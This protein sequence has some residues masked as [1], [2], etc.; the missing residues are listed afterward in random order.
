MGLTYHYKFKAPASATAA[1]LEA[2][3]NGVEEEAQRLGFEPT[4]VLNVVFVTTERKQFA[5]RLTPG[6]PVEDV[7]LKGADL[8]D[9]SRVWHHDPDAGACWIPPSKGVFLVATDEH[10]FETIFGFFQFPETIQDTQHRVVA[11][12]GLKGGWAFRDHVKSPD[13][14]FR[15][16]VRRFGKA[17]YLEEEADEF[18]ADAASPSP[19]ED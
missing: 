16:I 18:A 1:E 4:L 3:L 19:T 13:R 9:D 12:T 17:G 6:W 7:R 5:R 10:G 14:R 8:P 2:F 11:E 15:E